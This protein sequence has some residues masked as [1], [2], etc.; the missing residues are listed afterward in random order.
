MAEKLTISQLNKIGERLRKNLESDEDLRALDDFRSSFTPAYERVFEYL[1]TLGLNPG[2]RQSKTT[3]SIRAKLIRERTRLSKM[4]DIAGCRVVVD[5]LKEQ[6]RVVED[7][8][9]RW[10]NARVDDRRLKPSH[11]YRAVHVIAEVDGYPVEIQVRTRLQHSWAT[12][13]EKLGDVVHPDIKYGGGPDEIRKTLASISEDFANL[14][15]VEVE[16]PEVKEAV[17]GFGTVEKEELSKTFIEFMEQNERT[18][19]LAKEVRE[20]GSVE[21]FLQKHERQ[22]AKA[23]E[24]LNSSLQTLC[25]LFNIRED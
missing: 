6:D 13:T 5:G 18:K 20:L 24:G 3:L 21:M 10:P 19:P 8:K 9:T 16:L 7:L 2:G 25:K 14:E 17:K 23:R 22:I 12:A 1:S 15:F 11:G 4:Q